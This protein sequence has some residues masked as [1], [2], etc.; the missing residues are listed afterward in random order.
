MFLRSAAIP[1]GSTIELPHA[2]TGVGGEN[3]APDLTWGDAPE[4]TRSFR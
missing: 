4:G 3:V 1:A 2:H